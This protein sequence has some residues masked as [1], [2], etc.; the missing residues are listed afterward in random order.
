MYI[1]NCMPTLWYF[2]VAGFLFLS[3][4][5]RPLQSLNLQVFSLQLLTVFSLSP[6]CFTYITIFTTRRKKKEKEIHSRSLPLVLE[7]LLKPLEFLE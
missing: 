1:V 3:P 7:H 5:P 4:L 6:Y 2:F